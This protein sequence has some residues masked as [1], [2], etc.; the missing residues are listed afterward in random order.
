MRTFDEVAVDEFRSLI[1]LAFEDETADFGQGSQ[2]FLRV[3]GVGLA[4]PERLFVQLYLL[5]FSS[6]ID[7]R[8]EVR[9]AYRQ[10]LQPV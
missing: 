2:R 1:F 7:H 5:G 3:I 10:G 6:S 4:A 9:V 8:S